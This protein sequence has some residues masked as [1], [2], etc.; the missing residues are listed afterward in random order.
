MPSPSSASPFTLAVSS[1]MVFLDLPHLQRVERIHEL[2]FAVEIWDWTTKDI[3]ALVATGA[4]FTSMTG[5]VTGRLA[6][7]EGADELLRTAE[8]SIPAAHKLGNPSLNLHGTGLGEGGLPVDPCHDVTGA[9]WLHAEKTLTRIAALG[10]REGVTFVL[11]NLNLDVDHPG[12]PFARAA[13]TLA[14]V[15]AVASPHLRMNLDIYHAQIGEGNL[16]E[17]I[18]RAGDLIGEIQVAD[19]PGRCEP[20]TGEINYASIAR[21]LADQGYTGVVGLESFASGDSLVALERFRQAFTLA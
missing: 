5:Y 10:E 11:E 15:E 7:P 18:R 13:D 2:G 4:H 14:L 16:I 21:A 6:D 12:V 20:G 19:V 1:E 9:M 17:L 8:L 3:D